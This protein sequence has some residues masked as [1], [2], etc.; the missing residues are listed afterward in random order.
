MAATATVDFVPIMREIKATYEAGSVKDLTMHDGSAIRL[1][2]MAKDWDP[3]DRLSATNA[4][5][6]AKRRNEIL[7]GLLYVNENS[8]DLH[9]LLNTSDTALN[10]FGKDALCP[11]S[12]A[13][14]KLNASLR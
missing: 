11:G 8:V 5:R 4:V 1:H 2:K 6:E 7:T 13:L 12:D 14:A 9:E 10:S 3:S